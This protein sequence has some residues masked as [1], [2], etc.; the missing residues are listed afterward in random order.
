MG[1]GVRLSGDCVARL[2]GETAVRGCR[3][4]HVLAEGS[5][6][7]EQ[8]TVEAVEAGLRRVGLGLGLGIGFEVGG[9][10]PWL[11][12]DDR[13]RVSAGVDPHGSRCSCSTCCRHACQAVHQ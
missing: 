3:S 8:E 1:V 6:G 9:G 4:A 12:E 11:G 5:G 13:A 10:G 7:A 2:C